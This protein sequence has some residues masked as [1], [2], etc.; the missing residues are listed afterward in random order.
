MKNSDNFT[1]FLAKKLHKE[2]YS[3]ND[4]EL[5]QTIKITV[6]FVDTLN[7]SYNYEF[8]KAWFIKYTNII[9]EIDT[10]NP[11]F[12]L[13]NIWGTE[14]LNP[15]YNNSVKIA[16][17]SENCIP[18]LN[19]ADYAFGQAHIMYL[20]RS[21]KYPFLIFVLETFKRNNIL[22][23]RRKAIRQK[24]K[25]FCAAVISNNFGNKM[26]RLNFIN[27]LNKYKKIDMGGLAFNNVGGAVKNKIQFLSS[28]KFSISME[29]S[30]GDGYISEKIIDSLIAGTI[31]IYYGDYMVDEYINNKVYILIKGE[32]DL[33]DKIDYI[34]KID[35]DEHLYQS[36]LQENI[37]NEDYLNIV[38]KY[39]TER[40]KFLKNIFIQGKNKAKRRDKF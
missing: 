34:K 21:F 13:Y 19:E 10:E 9:F 6:H 4:T 38:E 1:F 8:L 20:D 39:N 29:N 18:D 17:Y 40:V 11:D 15:K 3:N 30:N 35:N 36:I 12:L 22:K 33:N 2:I 27:E 23:I 37:F 24:K 16:T 26:F 25:K 14:H 31:P 5:N 7:K 32:K 28:Y